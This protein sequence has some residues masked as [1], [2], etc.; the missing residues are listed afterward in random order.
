MRGEDK[1]GWR[2]IV[3]TTVGFPYSPPPPPPPQRLKGE[4]EE[5][6]APFS[7][8]AGHLAEMMNNTIVT[9][10]WRNVV[11]KDSILPR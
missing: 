7:G 8:L 1:D 5:E 2:N 4:E 10:E 11:N 9:K 6:D 3:R